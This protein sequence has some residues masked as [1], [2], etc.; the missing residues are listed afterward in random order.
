[1]LPGF[2]GRSPFRDL[3]KPNKYATKIFA[4]VDARMIYILNMEIYPGKQ[5]SDVVKRMAEPIS[6][7]GRNITAYNWFTEMDL[8]DDLKKK[9]NCPMSALFGKIRGSYPLTLFL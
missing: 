5:P 4:V 6:G 1:M 3:D 7:T 9:R 2:R 8:V